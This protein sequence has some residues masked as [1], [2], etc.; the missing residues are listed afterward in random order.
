MFLSTESQQARLLSE[1]LFP[2][3]LLVSSS[4]S[5]LQCVRVELSVELCVT[6]DSSLLIGN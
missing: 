1:G 4:L 3:S 2:V 6:T 5:L